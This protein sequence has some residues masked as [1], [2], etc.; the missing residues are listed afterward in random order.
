MALVTIQVLEGLERGRIYEDLP[1]PITIGREEDNVIQLNDERV[2]RFHT[3]IQDDGERI[4]LTD[5][6]STNGTRINGHPVQMRVLQIGDQLSIG[7]CLLVYGSREQVA[8]EARKLSG[9]KTLPSTSNATVYARDSK[10]PDAASANGEDDL[11]DGL[12][13][14]ND[15]ELGELFPYGPPEPPQGLRPMQAAQ[16]SDVLAYIHDQIR[17]IAEA[18]QEEPD[19]N[20]KRAKC[21]RIDWTSWQRLLSIEMELAVYLR[22]LFDPDADR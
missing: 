2:S 1:T 8:A 11:A 5:L 9:N 15:D 18:A 14:D 3:K 10:F 19:P 12:I 17:M 21:M 16:V 20:N 13:A 7:R 6:E 4:I 22:K